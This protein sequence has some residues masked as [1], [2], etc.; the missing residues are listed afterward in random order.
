[1]GAADARGLTPLHGACLG[2]HE[3]TVVLL[4]LLGAEVAVADAEGWSPLQCAVRSDSAMCVEALVR[5]GADVSWRN[6][7]GLEVGD[8]TA[9]LSGAVR[10]ALGWPVPE[11]PP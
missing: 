9:H 7:D 8:M 2:G 4:L 5:A 10:A 1:M 6:R 11:T 3:G